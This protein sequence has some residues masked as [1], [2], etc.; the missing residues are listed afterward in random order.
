V[1]RLDHHQA[2]L[3]GHQT[4][5]SDLSAHAVDFFAQS[6]PQLAAVCGVDAKF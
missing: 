6:L 4:S 5:A 3:L 1:P 2:L